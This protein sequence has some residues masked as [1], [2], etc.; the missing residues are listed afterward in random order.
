VTTVRPSSGGSG[1]ENT[2][3]QMA[4]YISRAFSCS[5]TPQQQQPRVQGC[6]RPSSFGLWELLLLVVHGDTVNSTNAL[7]YSEEA[8]DHLYL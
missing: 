5:T 7:A 2:R 3:R 1:K 4:L 8:F 6:N